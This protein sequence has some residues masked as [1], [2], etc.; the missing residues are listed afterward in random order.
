MKSFGFLFA[1]AALQAG[2]PAHLVLS[3]TPAGHRIVLTFDA[4]ADRGYAAQILHT[5]EQR[6]VHATF[7]MTGRWA[8]ANRDLV[9]R[10]ARDGDTFI[11]HTYDH[12]SFTG[13]SDHGPGL[14]TAQRTW[15][16]TQT[17]WVIHRLTGRSTKPYFRPPYG[18]YD[19]ATLTLVNRL[20]YSRVIMWT[21]D[22]LG[23]ER[24]STAA[25]VSRCSNAVR[26]GSIVLMHVG[27]QSNDAYALPTLIHMWKRQG[28]I[29][30]TVPQLLAA[31]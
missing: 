24:I 28:F 16:I 23:W 17:E 14:S 29:F 10:M 5:L 26:P 25:I 1:L 8:N 4:G 22:S 27:A 6:H 15:E 19:S 2:P 11:N 12:R 21:L 18:D 9:R 7:G 31:R 30:V 20:G 3:G 13:V